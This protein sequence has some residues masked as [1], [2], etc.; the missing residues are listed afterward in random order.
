MKSEA[1]IEKLE[2]DSRRLHTIRELCGYVE[3]GSHSTVKIFQDEATK[4]W[5][6][7]VDYNL[8]KPPRYIGRSFGEVIDNA[9]KDLES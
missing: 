6:I 2:K 5:F 4:D 8:N 9:A 1:E 7:R 3:D